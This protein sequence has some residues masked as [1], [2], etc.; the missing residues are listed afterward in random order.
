M[1]NSKTINCMLNGKQF[2]EKPQGKEIG[3]ITNNL[4]NGMTNITI[5]D[6]ATKLAKG[7][8]FKPA[9]LNGAGQS[10]WISQELFALDFDD[11]TTTQEEL[12]RCKEL[13][14]VP[15]FGYTS[16]SYTETHHK[17]RLVFHS[18]EVITDFKKAKKI[19]LILMEVFNNCDEKC[20]DLGRLFFGGKTL[21][22]TAYDNTFNVNELIEKYGDLVNENDLTLKSKKVKP[23]SKKKDELQVETNSDY[24]INVEA[25][26][27]LDIDKMKTIVNVNQPMTFKCHNDVYK[28]INQLDLTEYIGIGNTLVNCILPEHEDNTPSAHIYITDDGTPIYKCFGCEK[29][30]TII[31][32]TEALS[33]CRRSEAIE[34]IKSVY[35][36]KLVESDWT[37]QQKQL[38]I[39]SANY[40]DTEEFKIAFPTLS[41]RIGKRKLHIQKMLMHFTQYVNEDLQVDG[42]PLFYGSYPVLMGVCGINPNKRHTLSQSLSL[43]VLLNMLDKVDEKNI[44][45][46]ELDK[47]K[48]ISAKYG[49]KKITNFY[50]FNE[51]GY[52]QLKDSED[53]AIT[54]KENNITLKGLSKECVL[55]TFGETEA[56]RVYPQFKFENSL[57]TSKKSDNHT[58][59]I[60]NCIFNL[61][62]T[63][64]YATEKEVVYMLRNH[65]YESTEIQIKKSLQE[66]LDSYDL[67][68]VKASKDNKAKYN[69]KADIPNQCNIIVQDN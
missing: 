24:L 27:A 40:L 56:N 29:S 31:T 6:L 21:I 4:K 1:K 9:V 23:K 12:D 67:V 62:E 50:Q 54:L 53:K 46:V 59:E 37:K 14:I 33:G 64:G 11:G 60:T 44:P 22:H 55:R 2:K 47:A 57:G 66:I 32:L 69:I 42:K 5:E 61:I 3:G 8:T 36:L 28:H 30:M 38:M 10:D 7:C 17:F 16:F 15:C 18:N 45:K 35:D 68:K 51:Y 63:K 34:F 65:K 52:N 58:I 25:V 19:Q 13:N 43:F 39:D 20:K 48:H 41:K 26:K 49:F